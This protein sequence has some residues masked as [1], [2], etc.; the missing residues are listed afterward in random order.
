MCLLA[1]PH[2]LRGSKACN[3]SQVSICYIAEVD[4]TGIHSSLTMKAVFACAVAQ[5]GLRWAKCLCLAAL[6]WVGYDWDESQTSSF[7]P[8][9]E[10]GSWL[11][12][13]WKSSV[14]ICLQLDL[15]KLR[16][17][18]LLCRAKKPDP[19]SKAILERR[20]CQQ[21]QGCYPGLLFLF[22]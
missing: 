4:P 6:P 11:C 17:F 13:H 16:L 5:R 18:Y 1:Q 7:F 19:F 8:V 9:P 2:E 21:L 15:S 12:K 20:H 3:Y 10:I 14:R 22:C